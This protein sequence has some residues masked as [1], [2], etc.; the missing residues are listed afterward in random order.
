MATPVSR[1][2]IRMPG[3]LIKDPTSLSSDTPGGT[4]LGI[5]RDIYWMP[6]LKVER[7]HAEEFGAKIAAPVVEEHA[8]MAC[9]LRSWDDSMISAV[10]RNV[11]TSQYNET[12]ILGKVSG[13]GVNRAGYDM[14]NKGFKLFFL[15][16]SPDYH[17]SLIFY[18]A[19]P[20]V[21]ESLQLQLSISEEFGLSIMFEAFPDSRGWTY[22]FDM[23]DALTL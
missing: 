2:V 4:E 20:V 11:Q 1:N 6:G 23:R 16:D 19:V 15:P 5:V 18:N 14:V 9:T 10:F 13:S 8:I 17:R 7:L 22:A 21:D 12:G 3:R